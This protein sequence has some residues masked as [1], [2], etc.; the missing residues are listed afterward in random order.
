MAT[1]LIELDGGEG[2]VRQDDGQ[3][4]VCNN[5]RD[6]RG[7]Q[8]LR[9]GD[10]FLPIKTWLD[11]DRSLVGGLLPPGAVRVEVLDD[12]GARVEA[13]IGDGVY[14]AVL[15]QPNDGRDPVVC[16]RDFAGG[17]VRRPHPADYPCSRVSD[18]QDPC[19]ACEAI[20]YDECV[21][22][23]DWRGGRA[24]P[25][26]STISPSP[27][28]VCRVCGHEEAEGAIMRFSS[29][30]DDD[31]A[32]RAERVARWRAEQR[33]QR[34][35]EHK[36]TLRGV[37]FPIYAAE[38]WPAQIS[39]SGSQGGELTELTIAHTDTEDADLLDERP[40]I[41]VTTSTEELHG[42]EL[43]VARQTLE[44]LVHDEVKGPEPPELSDAAITLWFRALDRRQRAAAL[45]AS[46][47]ETPITIDGAAQPF[48]ILTTPSGR[49]VAVRRDD[50]LTVTIAVRDVDPAT[51]TI[52][53]IAD[54]AA[55]LL[56]PEPEDQ[57]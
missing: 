42:G 21:P 10:R 9:D 4:E 32:A 37:T 5:V 1:V 34:W 36:M 12:R 55:R 15:E 50:D 3:I 30:D 45:A 8:P 35:Y 48:L 7:G 33:V 28:V 6:E 52:E 54:P 25:D 44:Q 56:G 57:A 47:S 13:A 39:A 22:T 41:E 23:E 11:G 40:R 43:A 16:C 18:A 51:I 31:E 26:G 27:I 2:V 20:D 14:A 17:V 46:R 38:G 49:W 29:P 19:P 53:S 24:G